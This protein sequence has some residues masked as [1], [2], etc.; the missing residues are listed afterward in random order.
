MSRTQHE[1]D[2]ERESEKEGE[3]ERERERRENARSKNAL[4]SMHQFVLCKALGIL[5]QKINQTRARI[6]SIFNRSG[7]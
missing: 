1:V 5:A 6:Y 2:I 4:E 3:R 7:S